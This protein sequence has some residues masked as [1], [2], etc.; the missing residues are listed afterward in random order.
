[1]QDQPRAEEL[2]RI[3]CETLSGELLPVLPEAHRLNALIISNV[4]AIAAR[5][6]AFGEASMR[7]EAARIVALYEEELPI[8]D[9]RADIEA[10]VDRLSRRLAADVRAGRFESDF[11]LLD[12]VKSHLIE[13]TLQK[14]RVN[15]PR[16]LE[17]EGLA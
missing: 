7:H 10:I 5:E 17:A 4:M 8:T 15:N 13:T 3:A 6:L 11:A 16:Y 12:Q 14:L 2:L 1:M 9:N